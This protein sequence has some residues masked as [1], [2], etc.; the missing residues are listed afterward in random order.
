MLYLAVFLSALT[1]DFIPV[2]APPAWTI[3]VFLLVKFHLNPWI[4]VPASAFGSTLGR[5]LMS[6]CVPKFSKLFLKRNKH[7]ELQFVGKKLSKKLWHSWLFVFIFAVTPLSDTLLFTAAAI[8]K[9]KAIR[10]VPP[11]FCAKLMSDAVMLVVARYTV[12][13]FANTAPGALPWKGIFT[14]VF[15][16]V[17]IVGLLFLDGRALLQ[18]KKFTFNFNIWK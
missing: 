14:I 10:I 18:K 16:I 15:S 1:L 13:T 17:L 3:M 5:Y 9:V 4:A 8:A 11:F 7:E 6:L 2:I 12:A